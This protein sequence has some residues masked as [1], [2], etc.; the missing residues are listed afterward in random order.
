MWDIAVRPP[1]LTSEEIARHALEPLRTAGATKVS[2][3]I[4]FPLPTAKSWRLDYQMSDNPG[5]IFNSAVVI[6]LRG[7]RVLYIQMNAA[8]RS[9][10]DSLVA[11]LKALRLAP[12]SD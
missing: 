6:P 9:E 7:R 5:Q 2:E 1:K 4:Q 10:L 11:S 8:T 3:I 12:Q